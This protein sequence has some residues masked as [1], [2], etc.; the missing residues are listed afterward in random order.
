[1][2]KIDLF[3]KD[4]THTQPVPMMGMGDDPESFLK[5][6]LMFSFIPKSDNM[7]YNAFLQIVILTI[8]SLIFNEAKKII[9]SIL[10]TIKIYINIIKFRIEKLFGSFIRK[11]TKKNTIQ[12]VRTIDMITQNKD[13][14]E[15][16]KAVQWYLVS[17]DS[18]N[19]INE[20]PISFDVEKR[21]KEIKKYMPRNK[22]KEIIYKGKTITFNFS[23]VKI[24][25]N[26][27]K[28]TKEKEIPRITLYTMSTYNAKVDPIEEFCNHC[29]KEYIEAQTKTQW[30][31][32]IY[33]HINGEWVGKESDCNKRTFDTVTLQNG[34]KEE[35][36]NDLDLF[37]NSEEWYSIREIPYTRGYLFYGHPGTG[38]TSIIKVASNYTK[39]DIHFIDLNNIKDDNELRNLFSKIDFKKTIVVI[40]DIDCMT[41]IV[42]D[43]DL[44][45]EKET[46]NT[47]EKK[48]EKKGENIVSHVTLSGLLNVIDGVFECKG[49]ILI[50][51]S[52]KP[53]ILDEAL[54][55][56][57][58]VDM[59]IYFGYCDKKQIKEMYNIF[60]DKEEHK[61]IDDDDIKHI[62]EGIYA[63]AKISALFTRYR[64][65][66]EKVLEEFN[67][68]DI[69]NVYDEIKKNM[70][71]REIA[72]HELK[73]RNVKKNELGAGLN[74]DDNDDS[75][76]D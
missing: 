26:N 28:K 55:R 31:Q 24:N 50:M 21:Q 45:K 2:T 37:I 49:R 46:E 54:I 16:Y 47:E 38:K 76:E 12:I 34:L 59:R 52:N 25:I 57:G 70:E 58:R 32:M 48:K 65:N 72:M 67:T 10:D 7:F 41:N 17:N 36:K 53:D 19:Y 61:K 9:S 68:I 29:M 64:N 18:T 40:E 42:Q 39:R 66:P 69:E 4:S 73:H 33:H 6:I 71:K 1:M 74:N 51:T 14:N 75:D 30:K 60:F 63:P 22:S 27:G 35:I 44:N 11:L 15:A 5:N 62:P 3:K 56:D 43:R 20:T 13:T 23:D 8:V